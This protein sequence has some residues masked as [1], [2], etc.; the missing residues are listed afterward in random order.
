MI[1]Q[2]Y[3][4]IMDPEVNP[5]RALPKP[6]RFRLMAILALMWCSVFTVW[7]GWI[8]LYGP[9]VIA[10]LVL[11]I[12]VFFTADIFQRAQ[13]RTQHHRDAMKNPRDGTALYDDIWGG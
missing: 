12:G 8:S 13:R 2:S 9:S 4:I 10:H 5:L 7:T 6:V 3:N 11:L 1:R